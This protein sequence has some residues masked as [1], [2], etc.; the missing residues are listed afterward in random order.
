MFEEEA[1]FFEVA[2]ETLWFANQS[3]DLLPN[4]FHREFADLARRLD[5]PVVAHG[6][7]LSLGT[8]DPEDAARLNQWLV[9]IRLDP[10]TMVADLDHRMH[11]M[12]R[13]AVVGAGPSS[14]V[15]SRE[16]DRKSVV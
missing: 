1:D 9:R 16:L 2:P 4:G 14:T 11:G 10:G 13:E 3:G 7:G 12:E 15:E 8:T 5:K 6:V